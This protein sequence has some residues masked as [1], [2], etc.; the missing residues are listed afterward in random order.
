MRTTFLCFAAI[1]L[2][3]FSETVPLGVLEKLTLDGVLFLVIWYLLTQGKG[4]LDKF[5]EILEENSK[6]LRHVVK[7]LN[8]IESFVRPDSN[9][10]AVSQKDTAA[11]LTESDGPSESTKCV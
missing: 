10:C 6:V 7:R 9:A 5:A 2:C 8:R 11:N 3:A 4:M 1:S